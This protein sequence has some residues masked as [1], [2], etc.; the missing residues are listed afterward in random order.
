MLYPPDVER[1]ASATVLIEE[2]ED[3]A[4]V[5]RLLGHS[6]LSTTADVC[7]H[8]TRG[9]QQHEADRMDALLSRATGS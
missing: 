5:S 3:L 7:A 4:V 6:N 9:V 8:L 2:R 1:T